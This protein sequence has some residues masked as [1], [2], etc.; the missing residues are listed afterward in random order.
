MLPLP[1]WSPQIQVDQAGDVYVTGLFRGLGAFEHHQVQAR[2]ADD[3]VL[4]KR[5]A[6]GRWLWAKAI[7]SLGVEHAPSLRLN[8]KGTLFLTANYGARMTFPPDATLHLFN[9]QPQPTKLPVDV[10]LQPS[11]FN[12]MVASISSTGSLLWAHRLRLGVAHSVATLRLDG[13]L[14]PLLGMASDHSLQP[15]LQSPCVPDKLQG[16]AGVAG[17]VFV[18]LNQEGGCLRAWGSAQAKGNTFALLDQVIASD[19]SVYATGWFLKELNTGKG[20]LKGTSTKTT[21]VIK[22]DAKGTFLWARTFVSGGEHMGIALLPVPGGGVYLHGTYSADMTLDQHTLKV[23]SGWPGPISYL[24]RLDD[25]GKAQWAQSVLYTQPSRDTM[26]V[27]SQGR[28][29]VAVNFKGSTTWLSQS[30]TSLGGQDILLMT[31]TPEG[32]LHK[33]THLGGTRNERASS[34]M[35]GLDGKLYLVGATDS[36][37]IAVGNDRLLTSAQAGKGQLSFVWSFPL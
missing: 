29:H 15:A 19:Q 9:G 8:P 4:A 27:D 12:A 34:L 25:K 2:G 17:F 24:A 6:D 21:F 31:L 30:I 37:I 18:Q 22:Y 32:K 20:A 10:S 11:S 26:V 3:I 14:R 16:Q 5:S 23:P 36:P 35:I 28:L 7:G 33:L 13:S 1:M